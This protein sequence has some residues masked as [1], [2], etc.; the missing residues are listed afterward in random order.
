VI[1]AR[2]ILKERLRGIQRIGAAL[3][4]AG[5]ALISAGG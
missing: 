2:Y 1:L 5:A 4:L 3:A